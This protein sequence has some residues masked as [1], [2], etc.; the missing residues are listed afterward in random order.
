MYCNLSYKLAQLSIPEYKIYASGLCVAIF[1]RKT[2]GVAPNELYQER[3]AK[4][5]LSALEAL[6]D[7][8]FTEGEP[9][10]T[11]ELTEMLNKL[12]E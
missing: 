10:N 7:F 3:E 1:N 6:A 11:K 2:G 4:G 12:P 9:E 5:G 8:K